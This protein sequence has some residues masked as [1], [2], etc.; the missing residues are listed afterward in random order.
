MRGNVSP[1]LLD[2]RTTLGDNLLA[3]RN[4]IL[5]GIRPMAEQ[6]PWGLD[7]TLHRGHRLPCFHTRCTQ[8]SNVMLWKPE[9]GNQGWTPGSLPPPCPYLAKS[10]TSSSRMLWFSGIKTWV[11]RSILQ[12]WELLSLLFVAVLYKITITSLFPQK[13]RK[14][15]HGLNRNRVRKRRR[16]CSWIRLQVQS[17]FFHLVLWDIS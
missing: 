16:S 1:S 6:C 12:V 10:L 4:E 11:R 7:W 3:A 13:S 5:H 2:P 9:A 14:V 15:K 17:S 8:S